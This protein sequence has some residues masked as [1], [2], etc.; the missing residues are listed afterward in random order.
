M[1]ADLKADPKAF[2]KAWDV[3]MSDKCEA[4]DR[5]MDEACMTKA[6]DEFWD[7]IRHEAFD[8]WVE[9]A[10]E[11]AFEARHGVVDWNVAWDAAWSAILACLIHSSHPP[12]WDM[13]YEK[14]KVWAELSEEPAATLLLPYLFFKKELV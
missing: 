14:L 7:P 13:S 5:I 2:D 12:Y 3:T 1:L 4:W 10:D 6:W 9:G 8:T 11:G